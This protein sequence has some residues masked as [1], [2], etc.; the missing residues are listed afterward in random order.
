MTALTSA[1]R[2]LRSRLRSERGSAMIEAAL[3]T[4]FVVGLIVGIMEMGMYFKDYVA[5]AAT[6]HQGVRV[7]SA[8]GRNAAYPDMVAHRLQENLNGSVPW[9]QVQEIWVYKS[10]QTNPFPYGYS[11]YA[12]CGSCYKFFWNG[13]K[14]VPKIGYSWPASSQVACAGSQIDRV[15]VYIKVRHDFLTSI[16]A[17]SST[18]EK[19]AAMRLEPQPPARGCR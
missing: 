16:I 12:D 7:A 18:I 1:R 15:G 19:S 11:N 2:G 9:D 3:V 8:A 4:P 14:L 10:N 5:T 6:V 17:S 13:T